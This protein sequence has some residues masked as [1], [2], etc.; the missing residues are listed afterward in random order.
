MYSKNICIGCDHFWLNND[1]VSSIGCRAFP[2]DIPYRLHIELEH[3]HDKPL[4]GQDNDYVYF[5]AKREINRRNRKIEIYQD[6]NPYADE[7]GRYNG[8]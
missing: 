1:D 7:N 5:P 6:S 2:D 4:E 8:K 3:S